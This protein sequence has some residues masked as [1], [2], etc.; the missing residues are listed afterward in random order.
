[1]EGKRNNL[2]IKI[3][4]VLDLVITVLS[5]A[6]GCLMYTSNSRS[7]MQNLIYV[8]TTDLISNIRYGL[9]FGKA[10][11]SYYGMDD[12]LNEAVAKTGHVDSMYIVSDEKG[13]MF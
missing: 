4:I 13:L 1:M 9:H 2:L 7:I 11:E 3:V 10:L 8:E 12:E 6:L 5:L